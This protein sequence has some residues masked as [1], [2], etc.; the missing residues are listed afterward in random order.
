MSDERPPFLAQKA[1]MKI[2][3][4]THSSTGSACS[5]QGVIQIASDALCRGLDAVCVT[6]HNNKR[7]AE[8]AELI[9]ADTSFLILIGMEVTAEEG[10]FL[11]FGSDRAGYPLLPY[12]RLRAEVDL[13]RCAVIPAHPY[14]GGAY[15]ETV[16]IARRFTSDFCGLEVYSVNMT[17]A[18]SRDALDLAA[19]L[20]LP[21]IGCSDSHR[22]GTA[23]LNYTEFDDE[24]GSVEQLVAAIKS[25]RFRAVKADYDVTG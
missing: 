18:D 13:A 15:R 4:H 16:S 3:L 25:G 17:E 7:A 8:E 9:T 14:R 10:D 5:R 11:I 19:E 24:I 12:E 21:A 2:D 23:G 20:G 6:D 22:P 1:P